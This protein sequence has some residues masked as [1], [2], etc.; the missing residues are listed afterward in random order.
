MPFVAPPLH[1]K[2]SMKTTTRS[3]GLALALTTLAV[4]SAGAAPTGVYNSYFVTGSVAVLAPGDGRSGAYQCN[5]EGTL[6]ELSGC[7]VVTTP[8]ANRVTEGGATTYA[9]TA[10]GSGAMTSFNAQARANEFA[11]VYPNDVPTVQLGAAYSQAY[12]AADLA[13]ASL[14]ATVRNNANLGFVAGLTRADLHDIVQ[15]RVGGATASTVTRVQF[16]FAV[17][18]TLI[19]DQQTTIFGERGSGSLQTILRLDQIDSAS[20]NTPD[21]WLAASAEWTYQYGDLRSNNAGQDIR[22]EHVGGSWTSVSKEEMVF[23]GWMDIIG[24]SAVINPTL[25]L[26]LECNIGLQC[27][28][29]NTAKFRF[30][31]LP[32]NVSFTSASGVFLSALSPPPPTGDVPEPASAALV[33]A[34]LACLRWTARRSRWSAR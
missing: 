4:G 30:I 12:T 17:D 21:Y 29:G 3:A 28:Y 22:G 31:D 15:L 10:P 18:G 8:G 6:A 5:T 9:G 24:D 32:S 11:Y 7:G 14:R 20:S 25:S 16:R 26:A 34:G 2:E 1:P 33:L 19:D 13:T 27:D 23:D